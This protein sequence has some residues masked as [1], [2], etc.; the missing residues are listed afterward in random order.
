MGITH[1]S[2]L[3]VKD[4]GYYF[5]AKGSEVQL[6]DGSGISS[7]RVRTASV[8]DA[9]ITNAKLSTTAVTSGKLGA[10][11]K[12]DNGSIGFSGILNSMSTA[13]SSVIWAAGTM[14]TIKATIDSHS[15]NVL[16]AIHI[17]WSGHCIDFN[18]QGLSG[19]AT[20]SIVAWVAMG[21]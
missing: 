17:G 1:F 20:S 16:T 13:L 12:I 11:L 6:T 10:G 8:V 9:A 7:G 3:S 19:T 15:G 5:G 21:L 4:N 2:D 14:K 18:S